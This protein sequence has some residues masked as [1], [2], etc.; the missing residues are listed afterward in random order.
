MI[1]KRMVKILIRGEIFCCVEFYFLYYVASY[2]VLFLLQCTFLFTASCMLK[3]FCRRSNGAG[4]VYWCAIIE[5]SITVPAAA[6]AGYCT[7]LRRWHGC[8]RS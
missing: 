7:G 4:F 8:W 6:Q 1:L 3:F 2:A 5:I